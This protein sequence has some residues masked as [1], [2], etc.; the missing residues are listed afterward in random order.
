MLMVLIV[1][2]GFVDIHTHFDGQAP[3]DPMLAPS[4]IPRRHLA[5]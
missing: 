1:T 5:W 4:S 2:P 3:R